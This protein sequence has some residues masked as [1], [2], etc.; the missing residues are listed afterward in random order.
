MILESDRILDVLA[1]RLT[2]VSKD[3]DKM[4]RLGQAANV[5]YH[6]RGSLLARSPKFHSWLISTSGIFLLVDGNGESA[7]ERTSAMTFVSALLAQSLSDE[8]VFCIHYFCGLHDK[9]SDDPN[10]PSGLLRTLLAQLVSLYNFQVGFTDN[11]DY[12]QFQRFD[13]TRLCS[14]FGELVKELPAGFILVCVIDGVSLYE[15]SEWARDLRSILETLNSLTRDQNVQAAFK[16]LATSA[17]TSRQAT[18]YIPR[19]DHLMLPLDAGHVGD[20]PMT[21][22]QLTM[23]ARRPIGLSTRDQSPDSLL[24]IFDEADD[25]D[26]GFVDGV[27]DD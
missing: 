25:D 3:L 5:S 12:H 19:E 22:R 8:G 9:N 10:G 15:T 6:D 21:A 27:F 18:K 17:M 1:V 20:S 16:V 14:M 26:E 4:L 13:I 23:Q 24:S 7:V 11:S 2:E